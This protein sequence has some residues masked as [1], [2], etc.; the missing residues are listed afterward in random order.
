MD[1]TCPR[2]SRGGRRPAFDADAYRGRHVVERAFNTLK[3]WRAL[4]SRY[5]NLAIVYRGA[6]VP[7]DGLALRGG[8]GAMGAPSVEVGAST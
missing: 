4:A 3:Q 2:G 8:L 1:G 5:D 7:R 6:A